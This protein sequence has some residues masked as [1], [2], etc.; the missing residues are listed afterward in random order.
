MRHVFLGFFSFE[1][2]IFYFFFP[3]EGWVQI[4]F[5][6]LTPI[7]LYKKIIFFYFLIYN[8]DNKLFN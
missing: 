3:N 2:G 7:G 4:L 5:T 1:F 6:P 8:N